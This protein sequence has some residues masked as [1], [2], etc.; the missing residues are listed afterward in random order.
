MGNHELMKHPK[1][2]PQK[3]KKKKREEEDNKLKRKKDS[4][5]DIKEQK[6]KQAGTGR[7]QVNHW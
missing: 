4:K 6:W 1:R 5:K 3:K 2:T 7:A